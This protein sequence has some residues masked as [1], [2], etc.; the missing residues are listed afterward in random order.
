MTTIVYTHGMLAADSRLTRHNGTQVDDRTIKLFS[1]R[2][3]TYSDKRITWI[4]CAGT[5]FDIDNFRI[6]LSASE[7]TLQDVMKPVESSLSDVGVSALLLLED[8]T[9]MYMTYRLQDNLYKLRYTV[10]KGSFTSIG[11]GARV[12]RS[13]KSIFN[14]NKAYSIAFLAS[15]IDSG[16]GGNIYYVTT[17]SKR[18]IPFKG[19]SKKVKAKV[20]TGFETL[21]GA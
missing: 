19:L 11:S 10:T 1:A 20:V 17:K 16:S 3:L 9:C 15:R 7:G 21:L 14:V 18:V 13:M 4:G 6:L 12:A 5:A 8:G 2:N